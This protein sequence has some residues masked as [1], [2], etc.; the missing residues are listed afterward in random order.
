MVCAR[1]EGSGY[2][3]TWWETVRVRTPS[4]PRAMWRNWKDAPSYKR[5]QPT[6]ISGTLHLLCLPPKHH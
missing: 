6:S 1:C 4:S 3:G 5:P 2:F